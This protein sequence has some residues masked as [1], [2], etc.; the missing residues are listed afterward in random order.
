M[1][2]PAGA[3]GFSYLPVVLHIVAQTDEAGLEFLRP[4]CPDMVL[5]GAIEGRRTGTGTGAVQRPGHRSGRGARPHAV[6]RGGG[7]MGKGNT[8]L[9]MMQTG[10][11]PGTASVGL[12][13]VP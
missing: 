10:G 9:A 12:E 1:P 2:Q 4:Q 11:W 6:G 5:P 7:H 8:Q 13:W 3:Q